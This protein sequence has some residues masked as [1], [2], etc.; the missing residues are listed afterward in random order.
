MPH[1]YKPALLLLALVLSLSACDDKRPSVGQGAGPSLTIRGLLTRSAGIGGETTGWI[2]VLDQSVEV[3]GQKLNMLEVE[4]D[5]ARWPMK[6]DTQVEATGRIAFRTGVERG[7][8][9]VIRV[10]YIKTISPPR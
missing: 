9:S 1:R 3:E 7:R 10:D 5:S 2:V 4:F 6:E 8:Y